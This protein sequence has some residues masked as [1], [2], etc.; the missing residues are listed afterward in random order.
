MRLPPRLLGLYLLEDTFALPSYCRHRFPPAIIRHAVWVYLRFTLSY[1]DVEE[2]LAERR[3]DI[4]SVRMIT[5]NWVLLLRPSIS[6]YRAASEFPPGC[7]PFPATPSLA[8]TTVSR[9]CQITARKPNQPDPEA[10]S[11]RARASDILLTQDA[12]KIEPGWACRAEPGSGVGDVLPDPALLLP[13]VS[14]PDCPTADVL[15]LPWRIV[16]QAAAQ[17][18]RQIETV[19]F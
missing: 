5:P 9:A 17:A 4:S 14:W 12:Y 10:G 13:A 2:L 8:L 16:L 19:A 11:R 18:H 3:L 1:R 6:G 15:R 7:C